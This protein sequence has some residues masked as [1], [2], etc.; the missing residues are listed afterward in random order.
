MAEPG[1]SGVRPLG[2][3]SQLMAWSRD[4]VRVV[5]RVVAGKLNVNVVVT[6]TPNT[7]STVVRDERISARSAFH[8][9]P[10]TPHAAT[11]AGSIWTEPA[12]GSVTIHHA[13]DANTDKTFVMTVMG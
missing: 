13:A 12:D 7:G 10:R 4:V 9:D 8:F 1:Y 2:L 11:V 3:P 6:L 5:N